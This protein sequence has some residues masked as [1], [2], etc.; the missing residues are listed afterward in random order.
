MLVRRIVL[1]FK[2]QCLRYLKT[3]NTN[4]SLQRLFQLPIGH[5]GYAN[6]NNKSSKRKCAYPFIIGTYLPNQM[7]EARNENDSENIK[8]TDRAVP[9]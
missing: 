8:G 6:P 2:K 3:T 7:T 1:C 9:V 4:V 5:Q